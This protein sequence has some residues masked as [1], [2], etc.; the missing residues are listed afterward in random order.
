MPLVEP[1]QHR[2]AL[3]GPRSVG[4]S[5]A[6][7]KAIAILHESVAHVAKPALAAVGLAIET[8]VRIGSAAMRLFGPLLAAEVL[9]AVAPALGRIAAA[10][11]RPEALHRCPGTEQRS[12]HR[13]VLMRQQPFDFRLLQQGR[14]KALSNL[15]VE[16]PI[17]VLCKKD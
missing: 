1:R 16:Q 8:G 4:H 6:D 12:V 14:E 9:F 3:G 10:I 7:R 15:G 13:E 17:A 2:L 5:T 11:L